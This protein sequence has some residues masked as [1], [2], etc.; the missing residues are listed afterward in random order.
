MSAAS[1]GASRPL[2]PDRLADVG[3]LDEPHGDVE[4]S[5]VLARRVDRHDVG[6]VQRR[7][8]LRLLGEAAAE[9]G[10]AREV[11]AHDLERDRALEGDL[12]A[13]VDDAHPATS[14]DGVDT[15]A[16]DDGPQGEL[17]HGETVVRR[18]GARHRGGTT[19]SG[20]RSSRARIAAFVRPRATSGSRVRKPRRGRGAGEPREG[21]LRV[22]RAARRDAELRL[23]H[24]RH[25]RPRRCTTA[26]EL[27]AAVVVNL[28]ATVL[29]FGDRTQIGA[30][31]LATSLVADLQLIAAAL[32]VGLR[33]VRRHRRADA[34][35]D[36][37]R[38]V[39]VRRRAAGQHRLGRAARGR[40]RVVPPPLRTGG[41]S[42]R[43][44][45]LAFWYRLLDRAT[46]SGRPRRRRAGGSPMAS[47]PQASAT[48][49]L[50]LRRMRAPLIV[51]IVI[52]AVSVLG[53]TL[54]PGQDADGPAVAHGLL[55]RLLLHELHG[56]DDRLRRDPVPVHL[57]PADVGD[58]L[59]LPDGH[60][61]GV[62]DRLAAGAAAGPRLPPGAGAAALQPQGRPA[63]RA[64]PADRRLRA[65]RRAAR[66]LVRRARPAVRRPR[67]RTATGSTTWSSTPTT[68]TCPAW[69][70]TRAT[71]GTSPSPGSTTRR[72]RGCSRSP[73]TTRR[74]SPSR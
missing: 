50:V 49:F 72:A 5:R 39:A 25:R 55:R 51:L 43:N 45:L 52:F 21:G 23:L 67:P 37:Q 20:D 7:R 40:D 33:R 46:T 41:R 60:R 12:G 56:D 28:I 24:R 73:T 6:V 47:S 1:A 13:A 64:V 63:A 31:H 26:Y 58:D 11:V 65:D 34:R 59:D 22:L 38:R 44:P 18:R 8:D 35:G 42:W 57:Q 32:V 71:P 29:K 70:P 2:H 48:I 15:D 74:T 16:A 4:P 36:G 17:G 14:G 53:L 19:R 66:P 10:V 69:S 30:V 54:I 61:L 3:A 9:L 27:F 62:R 68:P